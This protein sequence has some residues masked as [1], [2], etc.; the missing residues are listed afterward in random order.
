M[1][2]SD[3]KNF[4]SQAKNP[5]KDPTLQFISKPEDKQQEKEKKATNKEE[6]ASRVYIS[7]RQQ[8]PV[9]IRTVIDEGNKRSRRLVLMIPPLMFDD[10]YALAFVRGVSINELVNQL[11]H[12]Y[13]EECAEE[14]DRYKEFARG[15]L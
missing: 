13:I 7:H 8:I 5:I 1:K 4:K 15:G 9:R 10:L 14:I 3:N 2:M 6:R 11:L 12:N